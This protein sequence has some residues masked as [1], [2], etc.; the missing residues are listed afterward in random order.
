MGNGVIAI[1]GMDRVLNSQGYTIE[2]CVTCCKICNRAK[3]NL[4][5]ADW[6]TYLKQL[7]AT[8]ISLIEKKVSELDV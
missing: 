4:T 7:G 6:V 1:N 8:R 5:I 2:N 3:S